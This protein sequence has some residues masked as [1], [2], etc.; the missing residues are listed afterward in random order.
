MIAKMEK[1]ELRSHII[2]P[3]VSFVYGKTH[4]IR[5]LSSSFEE[6]YTEMVFQLLI[7][8][9]SIDGCC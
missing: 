6:G 1:V 4:P 5:I 3:F 7:I 8:H 2:A 9:L